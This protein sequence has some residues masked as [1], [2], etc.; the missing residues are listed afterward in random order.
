VA[1]EEEDD[2]DDDDDGNVI[3]II[4]LG[5]CD[6]NSKVSRGKPDGKDEVELGEEDEGAEA[7][8]VRDCAE[9]G[10]R[11]SGVV[12]VTGDDDGVVEDEELTPATSALNEPTGG[13]GAAAN[14]NFGSTDTLA[15][16]L[17]ST[18]EP[19]IPEVAACAAAAAASAAAN[20]A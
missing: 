19:S 5:G 14:D 1:D 18:G 8:C 2:D 13:A 6:N 9:A 12:K 4:A 7:S 3:G 15:L 20:G 11:I 16:T 17:P 10:A